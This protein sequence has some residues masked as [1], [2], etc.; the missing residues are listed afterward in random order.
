MR[1]RSRSQCQCQ[2][3]CLF[4]VL[5][6]FRVTW[7]A[8]ILPVQCQS[9]ASSMPA[10]LHLDSTSTPAQFHTAPLKLCYSSSVDFGYVLYTGVGDLFG[11]GRRPLGTSVALVGC[12]SAYSVVARESPALS[13]GRAI[14]RTPRQSSCISCKLFGRHLAELRSVKAS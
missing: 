12:H 3:L 2:C 1:S 10:R 13:L 11:G 8:N 6:A 14:D 5:T 7:L 4:D 9:S